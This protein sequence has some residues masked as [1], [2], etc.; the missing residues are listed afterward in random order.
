[1]EEHYKSLAA[2]GDGLYNEPKCVPFDFDS[3]VILSP[4]DHEQYKY[5]QLLS[6]MMVFRHNQYYQ[7]FDSKMEIQQVEETVDFHY[8]NFRLRGVLDLAASGHGK[9]RPWIMDHKTASDISDLRLE[10]WNFR[11]QFLFYAWLWKQVSGERPSGMYV[12]ILKKPQERRSTKKSETLDD[13]LRR[14]D[15]NVL[16]D[17]SLYFR[18]DWLP[19]DDGMIDRFQRYTLDPLLTQ[20]ERIREMASLPIDNEIDLRNLESL[21]LSPNTD[22]CTHWNVKCE[23]LD[24]CKSD[25]KDFAVE[26]IQRE[27]KH[28]ELQR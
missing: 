3:D 19:L 28:P 27:H 14:I 9:G 26:F 6:A 5:W 7:D 8:R 10:G 16:A 1:L 17:Q 25:F 24:L 21:L 11:F 13:F 20:F 12:N 4:E 15:F 23:F 18:R 22:A 2:G